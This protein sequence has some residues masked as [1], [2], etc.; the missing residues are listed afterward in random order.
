M[1][2]LCTVCISYLD[3]AANVG[4]GIV[5]DV[6]ILTATECRTI[7]TGTAANVHLGINDVCPGVEED[8]LVTLT[9]TKHIAGMW[10]SLHI[11]LDTRH[12][13]STTRHVDGTLT[14]CNLAGVF[15][16]YRYHKCA[17]SILRICTHVGLFIT[18]INAGQ[19]M[20]ASDVHHRIAT[21][22]TSCAVPLA[23]SIRDRA[24]TTAKHVTVVGVAVLGNR[25]TTL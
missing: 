5:D 24:A 9:C 16:L 23:W 12:A 4:D 6:T 7:D 3:R 15:I 1:L 18:A 10:V 11:S 8:A 22:G 25:L 21:Y 2:C 17:M 20:S 19:D 14:S 13:D